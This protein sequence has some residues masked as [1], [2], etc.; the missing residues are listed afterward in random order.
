L[1]DLKPSNLDGKVLGF[2]VKI[3]QLYSSFVV[4][5]LSIRSSGSNSNIPVNYTLIYCTLALRD[6]SIPVLAAA[7]SLVVAPCGL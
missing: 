7:C 3:V 1:D 5:H 6:H 2:L 4:V